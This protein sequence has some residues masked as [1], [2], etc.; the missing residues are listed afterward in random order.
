ML[1]V[2][3]SI[4]HVLEE[5][6][7]FLK[8]EVHAVD[9]CIQEIQ[10]NLEYRA[11]MEA[12]RT[13]QRAQLKELRAMA[14]QRQ[15][16]LEQITQTIQTESN[17][18]GFQ[19]EPIQSEIQKLYKCLLK[20]QLDIVRARDKLQAELGDDGVVSVPAPQQT[21]I[22]STRTGRQVDR[23]TDRDRQV[24]NSKS[25]LRHRDRHEQYPYEEEAALLSGVQVTG[26][27][28]YFDE[29]HQEP[30][31]EQKVEPADGM[32]AIIQENSEP[33]LSGS[34]SEEDD[35]D[36]PSIQKHSTDTTNNTDM[37][38]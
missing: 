18:S 31:L 26:L 11:Q 20:H 19:S 27:D 21:D 10:S 7:Y 29:D 38:I 37:F 34:K 4:K 8:D 25:N 17:K 32:L 9:T 28:E 1:Q 24:D 5:S 16:V 35:D 14:D 15:R 2:L 33:S 6:Q 3:Q 13:K 23:Q 12:K 36:L 30:I 22:D